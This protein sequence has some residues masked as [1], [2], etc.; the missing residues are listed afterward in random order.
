MAQIDFVKLAG[1]KMWKALRS[2]GL[3]PESEGRLI[4]WLLRKGYRTPDT[5]QVDSGRLISQLADSVKSR[6]KWADSRA[7]MIQA[8]RENLNPQYV[9]SHRGKTGDPLAFTAGTDLS[10]MRGKR[11]LNKHP[12][13][14]ASRGRNEWNRHVDAATSQRD[15]SES[16]AGTKSDI[17]SLL[18]RYR[19]KYMAPYDDYITRTY[20]AEQRRLRK[21]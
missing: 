13:I 5:F 17:A 1:N 8:I 12:D 20:G 21:G 2:G 3:M 10:T 11:L 4:N 14:I 16:L 7:N 9:T 15:F 18:Q 19:E 6:P